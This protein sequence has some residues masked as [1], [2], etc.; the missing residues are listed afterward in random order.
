[1]DNASHG[2]ECHIARSHNAKKKKKMLFRDRK[3]LML[4]ALL[5]QKL[6]KAELGCQ[7][8]KPALAARFSCG[9]GAT[10]SWL[11]DNP[12]KWNSKTK[13]VPVSSDAC[14][15]CNPPE[16][17]ERFPQAVL[18]NHSCRAPPSWLGHLKR[19]SPFFRLRLSPLLSVC[20]NPPRAIFFIATLLLTAAAPLPSECVLPPLHQLLQL[21]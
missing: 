3:S 11:W 15:L 4:E 5:T 6:R 20:F 12:S 18:P 17:S 14:S 1:M 8:P 21:G 9:P 13:A 7:S 19:S 10:R 2:T 16:Q